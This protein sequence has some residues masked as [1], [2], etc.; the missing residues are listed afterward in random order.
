LLSETYCD[1]CIYE[2]LYKT[3]KIIAISSES[4]IDSVVNL[5]ALKCI[6]KNTNVS[7]EVVVDRELIKSTYQNKSTPYILGYSEDNSLLWT[8]ERA[9]KTI[10][11]V[12]NS[13]D[14]KLVIVEKKKYRNGFYIKDTLEEIVS[15]L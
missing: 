3:S 4:C 12:E 9:P 2:K 10:V 1:H 7:V 11:S 13:G 6:E 14:Q 15:L 5:N 8:W